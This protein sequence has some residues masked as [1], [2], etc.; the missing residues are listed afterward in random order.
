[1][2][3][4]A[5][6]DD[7]TTWPSIAVRPAGPA[8]GHDR[9][10]ELDQPPDGLLHDAALKVLPGVIQ[11]GEGRAWLVDWHGTRGVLRQGPD[12]RDTSALARLMEDAVWLH[13]F[14]ARLAERGF[15]SPRPLPVFH[16][17]SWTTSG[18]MLW[19]VVSFLPGRVV[20]WAAVPPMEEISALLPATCAVEGSR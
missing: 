5:H 12:P 20:G 9:D 15:P 7:L 11:P 6:T 1:V 10:V 18:G 4:S 17:Q 3:I 8:D 16:G 14:L 2:R 19:E 13:A